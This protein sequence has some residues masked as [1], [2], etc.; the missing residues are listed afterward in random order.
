[1]EAKRNLGG[2]VIIPRINTKDKFE[3]DYEHRLIAE[4]E[5]LHRKLNDGE[6][7]HHI[8]GNKLDNSVENLIVL[9]NDDHSRVHSYIKK[10]ELVTREYFDQAQD[11]SCR[12][13]QEIVDIHTPKCR[14]CGKIVYSGNDMC[15]ECSISKKYV[16]VTNEFVD[17]VK[18]EVERSSVSSVARR[19]GVSDKTVANWIS[20]K[21]KYMLPNISFLPTDPA[22]PKKKVITNDLREKLSRSLREYW[23]DRPSPN[24]V[25]VVE[26]EKDGSVTAVYRSCKCA[27]R[28]VG[29]SNSRI[30]ACTKGKRKTCSGKFWCRFDVYTEFDY[31]R[32]EEDFQFLQNDDAEL[33]S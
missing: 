24:D 31:K 10:G 19:V 3:Y 23:K 6:V 5:I 2:Y 33:N 7:V 12:L 16:P 26:I 8:N 32:T 9:S 29:A 28:E 17:K 11:G 4:D 30:N 14:V 15:R 13:K 1:M 18:Q 22:P 25:P 27:E 21:R 20:G